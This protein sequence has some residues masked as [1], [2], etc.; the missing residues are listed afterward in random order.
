METTVNVPTARIRQPRVS[1]AGMAPLLLD[2]APRAAHQAVGR[3]SGL[4]RTSPLAVI[5]RL[6]LWRRIGPRR[7]RRASFDHR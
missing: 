2:F 6:L 1:A 5:A 7:A 4:A 3:T